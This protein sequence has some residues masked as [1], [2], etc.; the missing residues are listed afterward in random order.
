MNFALDLSM[1]NADFYDVSARLL[2]IYMAQMIISLFIGWVFNYYSKKYQRSFLLLWAWSWLAFFFGQL[3]SAFILYRTDL[4]PT[5]ALY[6]IAS[7]ISTMGIYL[8][9]VLLLIGT[10]ELTSGRALRKRLLITFLSIATLLAIVVTLSHSQSAADAHIRYFL[11]LGIRS[12]LGF[13]CFVVAGIIT[14]AHKKYS[15]NFGQKL[16]ATSFVVFGMEQ[17]QYFVVVTSVII[18]KPIFFPFHFLGILD[19][20]LLGLIG[21]SMVVWLLEDERRVLK[22]AN[23]DL[24]G[25]LYSTSHDL[26]APIASILGLTGLAR[27]D[28]KET[29]SL[30]YIDMIEDKIRRL[31]EL[32]KDILTYTK[33]S[34][35]KLKFERID[36]NKLIS[37]TLSNLRFGPGA[38]SIQFIYEENEANFFCSDYIRMNIIIGNLL[39]NAVKYHNIDQENPYVKVL[40]KKDGQQVTIAVEDNGMGMSENDIQH[41]FQMFY[42]A[43][44]T[45]EGSGL[46]LFIV[47]EAI[48]RLAGKIAVTSVLGKGSTFTL[49]FQNIPCY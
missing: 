46:G 28:I 6:T 4:L 38:E 1:E 5:Q 7:L 9:L 16:L 49:N 3:G 8:Q 34:K 10:Y 47:N 12:L 15:S 31:D 37:D 36:F 19:L 2:A 43:S 30:Q 35:L 13:I 41:I 33:N 27:H 25:F 29:S 11:R 32:I 26:R 20:L 24:D 44:L 18:G 14:F 23:N 39:S 40:F 45:V 48:N 17:L 21:L 42:R 22:K